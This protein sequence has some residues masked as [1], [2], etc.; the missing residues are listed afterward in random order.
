MAAC[1]AS[2][3]SADTRHPIP[4]SSEPTATIGGK[5]PPL[6]QLTKSMLGARA[7]RAVPVMVDV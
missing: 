4:A 1:V 3:A 7:L 2:E 6:A 5:F